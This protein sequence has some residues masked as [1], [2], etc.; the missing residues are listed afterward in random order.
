L[1]VWADIGGGNYQRLTP[2]S[3]IFIYGTALSL[4]LKAFP[5]DF[6]KIAHRHR[7]QTVRQTQDPRARGVAQI[8][9]ASTKEVHHAQHQ[10][11][12]PTHQLAQQS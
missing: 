6:R 1:S 5:N 12:R 10:Q 3:P 2:D 8:F 11:L 7:A 4:L 9:N